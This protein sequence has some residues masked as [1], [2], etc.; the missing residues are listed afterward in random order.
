MTATE[1]I[2]QLATSRGLILQGEIIPN[3]LVEGGYFVPVIIRRHAERQVPS[4]RE[5]GA[6]RDQAAALG[7]HVEY[8]LADEDRRQIEEGLRASFLSSFPNL[9]RNTF[10]SIEEDNAVIWIEKKREITQEEQER[11]EHHA[12][13]YVSL[14]KL[15]KATVH[16]AGDSNVATNMEILG[17][18]RGR[19]PATCDGIREA[20]IER[21]FAV[22]SLD[23]INRRFDALRRAGLLIRRPDRTYAL[24]LEALHR[25]GTLKNSRSPDVARLLALARGGG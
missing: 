13:T 2:K 24:T 15:R 20:L 23:W 1:Q 19:A 25:L 16:I 5:L 21:G 22:P 8:L 9:I 4:G 12:K 10:L 7:Y 14:F 3:P 6:L 17:L 18:V 11:V